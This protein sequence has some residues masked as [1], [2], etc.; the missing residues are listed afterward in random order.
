MRILYLYTDYFQ[1]FDMLWALL[2]AG[3]DVEVIDTPF[4]TYQPDS[5]QV[6]D[7]EDK[8]TKGNF[9]AV[10][11]FGYI[12]YIS[13]LCNSHQIPYVS[14]TYDS[15]LHS[16]YNKSIEN[17]CNVLFV[18]D[19]TEYHY[20]KE[21][22]HIPEL[23]HLPLGVNMERV[24]AIELMPEDAEKYGASVSFVG[25]LYQENTYVDLAPVLS[26]E[27]HTYFEQAFDYFMGK[28]GGDS[29]YDWFSR[30]DA[31]YLQNRLPDYLKNNELME[32]ERYFADILLSKPIG[33]RERIAMLNLLAKH[34]PVC[35]YT[36]STENIS[37]LN[38][39][40]CR[41]YVNYYDAMSKAFYYSKINLNITLHGMV[42]GIPLRCFDIMGAGGFLL[43]N[44]Q[45]ELSEY[46]RP[47]EEF[48][49]YKSF[50]E[51]LDKTDFYLKHDNLR[52]NI[53]A[54]GCGAVSHAHTYQHR[55]NTMLEHLKHV[56]N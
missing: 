32:N 4:F 3:C 16:L 14:W 28:W 42:S 34:F 2:Q 36:K 8:L 35:I 5:G 43:S 7:L 51:L 26:A 17:P 29:I 18:Y 13:D 19:R 33:S 12:P 24:R 22:F 37:V 20:L 53:A 31:G 44:Y 10:F 55:I 21:H 47:D 15:I 56:I 39:V 40:E 11:N 46:F 54:A 52:E 49:Y 23:Y 38:Q 6:N 41:P 27:E 50:D 25:N 48:V 9:Q 1:N 45:E 30:E